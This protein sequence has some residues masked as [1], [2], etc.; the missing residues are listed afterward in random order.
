MMMWRE[1]ILGAGAA[2]IL[3]VVGA[4]AD[5]GPGLPPHPGSPGCEAARDVGAFL[6][7]RYGERP[8][9]R[10]LDQ[11]G[12]L[13][14]LFVSDGGTWTILMSGP[15]GCVRGVRSGTGFDAGRPA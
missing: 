7:E 14:E 4:V 11:T 10:G 12:L 15:D 9:A 5:P 8:F 13:L 6:A 2:A 3:A 1:A